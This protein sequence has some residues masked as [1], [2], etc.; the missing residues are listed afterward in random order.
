MVD[1][2]NRDIFCM[3]TS[4]NENIFCV[5]GRL[6]WES[7]VFYRW[8]PIRK[9]SDDELW[10]FLWSAP[11]QTAEQTIETLV[12]CHGA[13]YD[14]TVMDKRFP[15]QSDIYSTDWKRHFMVVYCRIHNQELDLTIS[16]CLVNIKL[17]LLLALKSK[18]Y[19]SVFSKMLI[20]DFLVMLLSR[21]DIGSIISVFGSWFCMSQTNRSWESINI[22]PLQLCFMIV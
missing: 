6:W 12:R 11:E 20:D 9:A 8:I 3:M 10:C 19:S 18:L 17:P 22:E 2:E 21:I 14:V 15:F 5:T 13:H 1:I 7:T 16:S 4:S